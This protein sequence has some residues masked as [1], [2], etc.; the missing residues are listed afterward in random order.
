MPSILAHNVQHAGRCWR[1][2]RDGH[3]ISTK[4]SDNAFTMRRLSAAL[5]LDMAKLNP[6]NGECRKRFKR[7]A[8]G[9]TRKGTGARGPAGGKNNVMSERKKT[10]Q[11]QTSDLNSKNSSTYSGRPNIVQPLD[12]C[13]KCAPYP[14]V[15]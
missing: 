11:Q 9:R 3:I 1:V 8:E 10:A 13:K 7:S 12:K 4:T 5:G 15:Q 2:G 14:K 6:L